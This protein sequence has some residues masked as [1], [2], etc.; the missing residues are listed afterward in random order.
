LPEP[1]FDFAATFG[2]D[3]LHFHAEQ[4]G[5][6]RSNEDAAYIC[7]HLD[8]QAGDRVLDAPCGHGR[9]ANRLAAA[10]LAV[11]GVDEHQGFLALARAQAVTLGVAVD[12][13][14]GDLRRLPTD[15]PFDAVLCWFNSFGYFVDA[16]DRAVLAE[17]H[18]VLRP[19]GRLL[20]DGLHHDGVVRQFTAAPDA[21]VVRV[22][23]DALVDVTSFDPI[24]G[25]LVTE[26]TVYRDGAVRH[27]THFVRLPTVP[28]WHDWLA[29]AGFR[30]AEIT[31]R[32]GAPLTVDSW[33]LVVT[34]T[35]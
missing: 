9:I 13:R 5:E 28:E 7:D 20:V 34:A 2:P 33:E 8:L 29:G 30:S 17:F 24:G 18:R 12:Y 4:V 16:E 23:E 19:G 35:A 21:T 25:R 1:F 22:G 26:R 32:A 10:G 11:V 27:S 6:E 31:D 15:G 3:Y 14:P